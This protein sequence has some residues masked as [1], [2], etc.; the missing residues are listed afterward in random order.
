MANEQE[1]VE[2][3]LQEVA[4][5]T[6]LEGLDNVEEGLVDLAMAEN[7]G[8]AS[9]I[10]AAE[11]ASKITRGVDASI[12]ASRAA[13][14]GRAVGE[15]GSADLA[16]GAAMLA[17]SDDLD[18]QSALIG[19]LGAEDLADAMSMA[20]IAGQLG[21]VATVVDGLEMPI[22]AAFLIDKSDELHDLAVES[23]YR[24]S[25]TRALASAVGATGKDMAAL[26]TNEMAQGLARLA[27][28]DT[29]AFRS[30]ELA[31]EGLELTAEGLVEAAAADGMREASKD[32]AADAIGEI[33]A[34]SA[35]LG[36]ADTLDALT[37]DLEE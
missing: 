3:A 36:A 6:A 28:S 32:L 26:G 22:L 9:Q 24:S 17:A 4:D 14:L 25:A 8:D 31:E 33:A 16:E 35:E 20:A 29:F 2:R 21:A 15:A 37:E 12:I 27:I 23:I 19:A 34:G 18:V 11:A 13:A 5:E 10:M 30:E 1:E 7:L